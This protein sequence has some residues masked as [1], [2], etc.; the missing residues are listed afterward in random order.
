[1]NGCSWEGM[2]KETEIRFVEARE[3]VIVEYP[4]KW[5][6]SRN[7]NRETDVGS[8]VLDPTLC[9]KYGYFIGSRFNVQTLRRTE[10]H[11]GPAPP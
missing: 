7:E 1:M 8:D 9:C 6:M 5:I 3:S 11:A 2:G 4:P 10:G